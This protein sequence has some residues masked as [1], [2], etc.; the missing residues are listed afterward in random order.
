LD[1]GGYVTNRT[2]IGIQVYNIAESYG[3]TH[4]MVSD[5]LQCYLGYCRELLLAGYRVD[6]YGLVSLIPTPL[7]SD[8]ETTMA[9]ECSKVAEVLGLPSATV[10]AI[11]S[12]YIEDCIFSVKSGV[13]AEIRG[14]VTMRPLLENGVVTRVRASISTYFK[15]QIESKDDLDLVRVR[16]HTYKSLRSELKAGE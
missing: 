7:V 10:I 16:A 11:I 2:K 8:R 4:V 5:I 9:Y 3:V 1:R 6:F 12:A 13:I 15:G 14:L